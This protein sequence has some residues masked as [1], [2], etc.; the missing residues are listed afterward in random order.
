MASQEIHDIRS[1]LVELRRL[2]AAS[3]ADEQR[4][5][6]HHVEEDREADRWRQRAQLAAGKGADDLA[7][8]ALERSGRHAARAAEFRLQYLRQKE[9]VEEMKARLQDLE[10]RAH[11]LP[12]TFAVPLD[13]ARLE[14]TLSHLQRQEDRAQQERARLAAFAELERDE[15]A[16]KLAALERED[17][18]ERQL[19]ELKQQLGAR[20]R[21][22]GVRDS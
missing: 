11:A 12:H 7:R 13:T 18:L 8:A 3:M 10:I 15:V 21:G 4:M 1:R 17:Q 5:Y 14:R 16:E 19:A 20:G 9:H 22:S 2:L 6:Q